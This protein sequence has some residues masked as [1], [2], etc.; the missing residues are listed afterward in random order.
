MARGFRERDIPC[1][2]IYL[3][4]HYMDGYR[5]FTWDEERFP[6]PEKLTSDLAEQGFRVVTIVDPGVKVDESYPVYTEGRARDLFCKT[7]DGEEYHNA[8]WPGVCAFPDFTNSETREWWGENHK[9]LLDRGVAGIWCDMNEPS[10]F[11]PR[12]STM[13]G[14]WCIRAT[15]TPGST[16]RSTTP[17]ARSWPAPSARGS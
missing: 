7:N 11:I 3:D 14:T 16:P 9:A 13:P 17:T 10:L 5:V 1:D 2:V 6:D 15:T 8:V 12:Q 4:I